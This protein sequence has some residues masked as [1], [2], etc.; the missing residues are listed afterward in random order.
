MTPHRLRS[1]YQGGKTGYHHENVNNRR[2]DTINVYADKIDAATTGQGGVK[3]TRRN[4]I[5]RRINTTIDQ[6]ENQ[7]I[8]IV[9]KKEPDMKRATSRR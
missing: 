8:K 5:L 1:D 6:R 3:Y 2:S 4:E 9:R 7:F